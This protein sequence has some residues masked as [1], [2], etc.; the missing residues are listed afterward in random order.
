[1][2]PI[3]QRSAH[4]ALPYGG[5]LDVAVSHMCVDPYD[6]CNSKPTTMFFCLTS[7]IFVASEI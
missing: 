4:F 2:Y 7:N 3:I 6:C 1:V 5:G